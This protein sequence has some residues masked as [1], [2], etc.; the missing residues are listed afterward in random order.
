PSR[1][2]RLRK[3]VSKNRNILMAV[4]AFA[5]L[6]LVGAGVSTWQAVRATRAQRAADE[7]SQRA[8][9]NLQVALKALDGIYLQVAEERLPRDPERKKEDT[10]VLKKALEFYQQFAQQNSADAPVGREVGR[11][12]RRVGDIQRFVGEHAAAQDAYLAAISRIA[13]LGTDPD[14]S[15]E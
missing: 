15:Y 2:Y 1:A 6:L 12:Y 4:A 14:S 13:E 8:Q 5:M 7:E 9:G 11:A 10:E 3:F